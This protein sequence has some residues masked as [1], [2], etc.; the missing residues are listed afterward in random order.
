MPRIGT[1]AVMVVMIG[2]V[3]SGMGIRQR[4]NNSATATARA[5][6]SSRWTWNLL[7]WLEYSNSKG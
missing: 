2:G 3:A 5:S 7:E 6:G 4:H 1:V